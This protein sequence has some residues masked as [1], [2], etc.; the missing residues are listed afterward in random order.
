MLYPKNSAVDPAR[1]PAARGAA[2]LSGRKFSGFNR[3]GIRPSSEVSSRDILLCEACESVGGR[4][5][6]HAR[7]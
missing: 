1:L 7:R 4:R 5:S 2:H 3:L 6:W